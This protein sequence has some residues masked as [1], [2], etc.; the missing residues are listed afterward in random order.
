MKPF[1]FEEPKKDEKLTNKELE[2]F[3]FKEFQAKK[4]LLY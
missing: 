4:K 3:L 1:E 2:D